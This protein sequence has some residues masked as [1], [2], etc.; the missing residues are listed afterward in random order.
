[1]VQFQSLFSGRNEHERWWKLQ[2]RDFFHVYRLKEIMRA[3]NYLCPT[4]AKEC[5]THVHFER[6]QMGLLCYNICS[7][8]ELRE[9]CRDRGLSRPE[10]KLL[11]KK[12]QLISF[13]EDADRD[14]RFDRLLELPAE[15]RV[16]IY[17]FY[18]SGFDTLDAPAQ[19][20]VTK[21]CRL[22][23]EEA[24]PL[25]YQTCRFKLDYTEAPDF[26]FIKSPRIFWAGIPQEHFKW[27]K[28]IELTGSIWHPS[29]PR[30]IDFLVRFGA[31][32]EDSVRLLSPVEEQYRD[33]I[34]R[35]LQAL[36]E[37]LDMRAGN[38]NGRMLQGDVS[39][40]GITLKA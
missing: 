28:N 24:L 32:R 4:S 13:L 33:A 25:F 38:G 29:G 17:T 36:R 35:T 10:D 9:F 20:P 27:I 22:L 37:F 18:F 16:L 3:N 12:G 5:V 40:L 1:M 6:Y 15:L 19:P 23:R 8:H 11:L 21:V 31:A 7:V 26:P 34:A 30:K 39:M 14:L 2:N